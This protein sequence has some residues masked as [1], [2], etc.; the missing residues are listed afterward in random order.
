M[1]LIFFAKYNSKHNAAQK[2]GQYLYKKFV[3]NDEIEYNKQL[4]QEAS[5]RIQE[6]EKKILA[7]ESQVPKSYPDVKFLNYLSRKRILVFRHS[8]RRFK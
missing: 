1:L 5:D 2:T 3:F 6:L 7:L 4:L 8:C